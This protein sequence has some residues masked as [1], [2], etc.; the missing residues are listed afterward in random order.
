MPTTHNRSEIAK[1]IRRCAAPNT[2]A[3]LDVDADL[4]ANPQLET[5]FHR[6]GW[7]AA[8]VDRAPVFS[9]DTLM[10]ALYQSCQLPAYFGFNWDALADAL[11]DLPA[12]AKGY[13]LILKSP[14][15]LRERTP[16][17]LAT[18]L[19]VVEAVNERYAVEGKPFKLLLGV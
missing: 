16:D 3:V 4:L 9:K 1:L 18:F 8:V 10:H 15:L 13:V 7:F 11:S 14:E 17:V 19:D 5:E 2:L 12:S 6:V